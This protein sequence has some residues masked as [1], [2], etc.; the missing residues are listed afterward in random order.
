MATLDNAKSIADAY[1]DELQ[2]TAEIRQAYVDI[3]VVN[4]AALYG[5]F[6][7]DDKLK[8]RLTDALRL[9]TTDQS[10]LLR[11]LF[12]QAVGVFDEFIRSLIASVLEKRVEKS[13]KFCDLS[14]ALKNGFVSR[15]GR[16]LSHYGSGTV[17][18]VGYDFSKLTSSLASCFSN[19]EDYFIEARVFTILMGNSTPERLRKVFSE[20]GL[21]EPFSPDLGMC[22]ELKKAL[23]ET[24]KE[25]VA[26]MAEERLKE[27]IDQ[28]NDIAHGD[29]TA[30][31]SPD[32]FRNNI[33]VLSAL[34]SA[35]KEL[36]EK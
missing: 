15:S 13:A 32:E 27:L 18:G 19:D 7:H 33:A 12:V 25:R 34:T 24:R 21:P 31:L 29:L 30:A 1:F 14:E 16:V 4:S 2:S 17:N 10:A 8:N 5:A 3:I 26:H 20:L 6:S 23:G 9:K 22:L 36:C 35:F 11:G 28:R